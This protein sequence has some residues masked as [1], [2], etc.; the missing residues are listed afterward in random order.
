MKQQGKR[1]KE[2]F[3]QKWIVIYDFSL[4]VTS[5]ITY[6]IDDVI[7]EME[8]FQDLPKSF[9]TDFSILC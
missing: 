8:P 4:C 2:K 3:I 6:F 5:D 9:H 1:E 7:T